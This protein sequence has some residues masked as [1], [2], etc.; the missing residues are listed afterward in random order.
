[1]WKTS[2]LNFIYDVHKDKINQ[3]CIR[4]KIIKKPKLLS[5]LNTSI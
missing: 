2:T 3:Y 4:N 1:M 5:I